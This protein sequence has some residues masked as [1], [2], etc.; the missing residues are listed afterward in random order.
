[1]VTFR[2]KAEDRNGVK[3]TKVVDTE[4]TTG[5]QAAA[6]AWWHKSGIDIVKVL[7]IK[8]VRGDEASAAVDRSDLSNLF[9]GTARVSSKGGGRAAPGHR[10]DPVTAQTP[11]PS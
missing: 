6:M 5:A 8:V 7:T 9:G 1:M 4:N 3:H 11:E 2:V 10:V